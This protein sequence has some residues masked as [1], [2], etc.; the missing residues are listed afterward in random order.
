MQN[1]AYKIKVNFSVELMKYLL[2]QVDEATCL[3]LEGDLSRYRA[4]GLTAVNREALEMENSV[5]QDS[6]GRL[7]IPLSGP[8][9]YILKKEVLPFVGIRQ[10]IRDVFMERYGRLLFYAPNYCREAAW[11]CDWFDLE[12]LQSLELD[13]IIGI[14]QARPSACINRPTRANTPGFGAVEVLD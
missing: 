11:L 8:N 12:F 9:K 3:V 1:P 6:Y 13:G 7:S 2:S 4:G 5:Y 10:L 14:E